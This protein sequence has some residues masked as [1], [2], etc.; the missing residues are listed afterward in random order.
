[1]QWSADANAGFSTAPPADLAR[2][3]ISAGRFSYE[4]VNVAD[5]R[6][7]GGS[8]LEFVR[9]LVALRHDLPGLGWND[10]VV[11]DSGVEEAFAHR[12]DVAGGP[13]VAVHNLAPDPCSVVVDAGVEGGTARELLGEEDVR[14]RGGGRYDLDLDGYGYAWLRVERS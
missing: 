7:T 9:R 3:V 4:R 12:F 1:M 13:V 8:L 10:L 11:L 5:Q 6:A 14:H 2:P